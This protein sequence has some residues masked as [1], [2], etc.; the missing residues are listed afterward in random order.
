V[1]GGIAMLFVPNVE[2]VGLLDSL[3]LF[4]EMTEDVVGTGCG[5][6]MWYG[7]CV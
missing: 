2:D 4:Y 5:M 3:E 6:E 1:A 7:T